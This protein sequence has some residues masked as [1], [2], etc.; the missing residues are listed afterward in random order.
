MATFISLIIF[1]LSLT[2]LMLFDS[3]HGWLNANAFRDLI[4][5]SSDDSIA[6]EGQS[7][8]LVV[9]ETHG[10]SM[11]I[12]FE[13]L[14]GQQRML[15]TILTAITLGYFGL[16]SWKNRTKQP[17]LVVLLAYLVTGI[18]GT[19]FYQHTVFHHYIAYLFPITVLVIG[20][21]LDSILKI[22][23]GSIA[24][25]AFLIGFLAVNIP[26]IP[27]QDTGWTVRD[28]ERTA[29][30]IYQRLEPGEKYNIVLMAETGDLE[31]QNYRYFLT[32]T[33]KPPVKTEDR[34]SIETLFIIDEIKK[35]EDVTAS[36]IYE[37]VVF[38]NKQPLEVYTIDGGPRITVLSTKQ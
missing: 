6:P 37:I 3:Q 7:L 8:W 28:M 31:G 29:Q 13:W 17:G 27:I 15:N 38:P 18:I 36:P 30:S 9:R 12:L 10:R 32:T 1:L 25:G 23:F 21:V 35:L 5:K 26:Q 19:A 2:P 33:D 16:L 4:F 24:V 34:G 22:K 20:V 11:H 14:I